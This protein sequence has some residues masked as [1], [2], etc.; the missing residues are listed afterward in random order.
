MAI[1]KDIVVA[2]VI[3]ENGTKEHPTREGPKGKGDEP[4]LL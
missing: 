3:T 2:F 4:R 1:R